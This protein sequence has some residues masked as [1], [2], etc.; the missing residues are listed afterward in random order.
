LAAVLAVWNRKFDNFGRLK[1]AY[2]TLIPK[3]EGAEEVKDF[4]PI[5]LVHSFAKLITKV[6]ANRLSGKLQS[7]VSSKQSA[8]IKGRCIQD[9]FMPVQQTT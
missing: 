9:N 1:T 4:R 5:S 3:K 8:F 6:L 7:M 2:V